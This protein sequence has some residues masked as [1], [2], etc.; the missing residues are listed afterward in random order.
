MHPSEKTF[1]DVLTARGKIWKAQP[2]R[3]KLGHTTYTPDF[4]CP[5]D[6]VY[7]EVK[8]T[9]ASKDIEKIIR[10]KKA[11]P[12][13]VLKVVSPNGYPYYSPGSDSYL[14]ALENI[15]TIMLSKDITEIS[16]KELAHIDQA[17]PRMRGVHR[18]SFNH[19]RSLSKT[20]RAARQKNPKPLATDER[21]SG[22][23]RQK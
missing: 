2:C 18:P 6:D 3:F 10:F 9:C 17:A 7:Y 1:A 22:R 23:R 11:Y 5:D 4:Y 21:T 8:K 13:I 14:F 15:M 19:S 20:I 16:D 12:K